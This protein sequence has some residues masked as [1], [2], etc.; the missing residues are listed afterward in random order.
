M[1]PWKSV[2]PS[3]QHKNLMQPFPLSDEV[4]HEIWSNK[5]TDFRDIHFFESVDENGNEGPPYSSLR[6]R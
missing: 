4:L 5:L 2:F 6:F 1:L 3:N